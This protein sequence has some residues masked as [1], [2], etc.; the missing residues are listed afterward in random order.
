M[1]LS[2]RPSRSRL[3]ISIVAGL[4][5]LAISTAAVAGDIWTT[6]RSK[7]GDIVAKLITELP[8][9]PAYD[10]LRSVGSDLTENFQLREEQRAEAIEETKAELKELIAESE[11]PESERPPEIALSD[12]LTKAVELSL[13]YPERAPL[14]S[15]EKVTDLVERAERAARAAED[16]GDWLLASELFYRLSV[17]YLEEGRYDAD[18]DRQNRRLSI[19][20]LYTPEA[21]WELRN[22][23]R[24]LE[25]LDPLPEYN[26]LGDTWEEKLADVTSAMVIRALRRSAELNVERRTMIELLQGGLQ[27]VELLATTP[28][29][30]SAFPS[31][32]DE[33]K[34]KA[35]L[36][37]VR[38]EANAVAAA[39]GPLG[40]IELR[41][42]MRRLA[43]LNEQTMNFPD[44]V[45]YHEFGNGAMNRLDQFSAIIWPDELRRFQRQ[46]QGSFVGVGI[47]INQNEQYEIYVVS[48]IEGKPAFKA[49]I[50][51]NDIIS[52][53][54]GKSTAGFTLDQAVTNITGP[55]GT[56]VDLTI[57]RE[58][59]NDAGETEVEEKTFR[60]T[61]SRIELPTVKGWRKTGPGDD[62]WDWF[63]DEEAGLG[64]IRLTQ[65]SEQTAR[66]FDKA[67][68]AM[69]AKGLEGIVLDLRYNPGGLLDQ[70]VEIANRFIPEGEIVRTE[71]A[72]GVMQDSQRA[73]RGRA[74]LRDVPVIVLVNENSASASEIVSGAIQ[75]YAEAG[76][77]D[78]LIVG[79]RSFGKGSVQNVWPLQGARAA[80]KLTTQYYKLP[81]GRLIHRNPGDSQWGVDPDVEVE[82]LPEQQL[83]A[84]SL[85]RRADLT[86][87]PEDPTFQEEVEEFGDPDPDRLLAEPIDLQL[88]TA[89]ALLKAEQTERNV[90]ARA[91]RGEAVGPRGPGE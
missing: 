74:A 52:K 89:V 35:F 8:E 13:L 26:P 72:A 16:R 61:R 30:A 67:V 75:D 51:A 64:Y 49:G 24:L 41:G 29:L 10:R 18:S 87:D 80:M 45:L 57:E 48:P 17:L 83:E 38:S 79:S 6:A 66:D 60:I 9:S 12:A 42:V 81:A 4:A 62:D 3:A 78:G 69:R 37:G 34:V 25:D 22:R 73:R 40:Y 84:Y 21:L 70:A 43:G 5:T 54:N 27:G 23:R 50:R 31:V 36:A 82:M 76:V 58:T 91:D 20:R 77:V 85:R 90:Q 39:P 86:R 32:A 56:S 53:I 33:G 63:I 46:T 2:Y 44:E 59:E 14:L 68:S 15:S 88:Q 71:D 11:D 47:Q 1:H 28:E 65:F 55:E 7:D 19:I